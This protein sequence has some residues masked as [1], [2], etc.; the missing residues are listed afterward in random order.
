MCKKGKDQK[1]IQ[2]S[3]LP[4]FLSFLVAVA[5][6]RN[7][8][9]NTYL[10]SKKLHKKMQFCARTWNTIALKSPG[11]TTWTE[12]HNTC[13]TFTLRVIANQLLWWAICALYPYAKT[14]IGMNEPIQTMLEMEILPIKLPMYEETYILST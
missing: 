4:I 10:L 8:Y 6:L 1:C 13:N 12:F 14:V 3:N 9:R 11:Q 2:M 7:L 5:I